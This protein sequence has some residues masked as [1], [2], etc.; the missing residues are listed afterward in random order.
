MWLVGRESTAARFHTAQIPGNRLPIHLFL[1]VG[2]VGAGRVSPLAGLRGVSP[3]TGD[4]VQVGRE[5]KEREGTEVGSARHPQALGRNLRRY[6]LQ[7]CGR[8]RGSQ[9]GRRVP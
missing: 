9:E 3:D 6:G 2:G 1:A 8:A 5:Q 7:V 4:R